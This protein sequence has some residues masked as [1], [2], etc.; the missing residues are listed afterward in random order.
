MI[1]TLC[2]LCEVI[3][4]TNCLQTFL[5]AA[6][7]NWCDIPRVL[8]TL[9]DHLQ[10]K[11]ENLAH[12]P[13]SYFAQVQEFIDIAR[14]SSGGRYQ[15]HSYAEFELSDFH[16]NFAKPVISDLTGETENA[17]DIPE[18]LL[19]FSA[20]DPQATPSDVIAL[21]KLGEQEI[22]CLACFYGSSSLISWGK[23]SVKPIVNATSLEA[24]F[25]IC[26]KIVAAKRLKYESN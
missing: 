15:L 1:A 10:A 26:K 24:Q 18:H 6:R 25:H 22:K 11:I 19:G 20:I 3:K 5:Q 16:T 23:K 7:L 2:I 17:F 21:E 14:K 8:D 4:F 13:T 9:K 12:P